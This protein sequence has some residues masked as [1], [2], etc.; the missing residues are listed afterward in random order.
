MSSPM[1]VEFVD[2]EGFQHLE[3][4]QSLV[5]YSGR[6]EGVHQSLHKI[7]GTLVGPEEFRRIKDFV[8]SELRA[9]FNIQ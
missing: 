4:F 1:Y 8:E 2:L 7:N 6:H 5:S 9:H 3:V